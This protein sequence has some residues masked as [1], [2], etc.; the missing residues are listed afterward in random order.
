[1]VFLLKLFT[2]PD[3]PVLGYSMALG[4]SGLLA[5]LCLLCVVLFVHDRKGGSDG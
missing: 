3:T 2:T 4:F 1:M 5:L